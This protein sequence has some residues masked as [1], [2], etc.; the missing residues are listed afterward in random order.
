MS[1]GSFGPDGPCQQ[2]DFDCGLSK[3]SSNIFEQTA[4]DFGKLPSAF[5]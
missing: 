2:Q 5:L 4:V 1:F 3:L